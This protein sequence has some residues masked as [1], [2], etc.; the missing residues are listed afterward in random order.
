MLPS[1]YAGAVT[2]RRVQDGLWSASVEP[3][4]GGWR[5]TLEERDETISRAG[6]LERLRDSV[7]FADW[8]SG[9]LAASPYAA[10]YW[11]N[12]P[13]VTVALDAPA[14]CV[15]IEAPVLANMPPDAETF[16]D[17]F[18]GGEGVVAFANLGGDALLVVP[19]PSGGA[20]EDACAHLASFLRR[21][22]PGQIR[23]LW[24]TCA[25]AV[26]DRLS[27][28]PLWLSTSGTGVAWLHVRL[29]RRPKYYQ[30]A[31]YRSTPDRSTQ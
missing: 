10:F 27:D 12:P 14:E 19:E 3:V 17:H 2:E 16:R 20:A 29:D 15:L 6:F 4:A 13:L 22:A 30:Y 7:A 1:R 26:L 31:P 21:G 18:S 8:Y 24:R 25:T 5:Y 23:A 9:L 28:A 11:E